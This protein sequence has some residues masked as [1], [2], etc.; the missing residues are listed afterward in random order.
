MEFKPWLGLGDCTFPQDTKHICISVHPA[1][2]M[3]AVVQVGNL[4][5]AGILS[6]E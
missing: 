3:D 1:E 2:E 6:R 5:H 4:G